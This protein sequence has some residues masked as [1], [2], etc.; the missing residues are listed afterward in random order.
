V[1]RFG[2]QEDWEKRIAQYPHVFGRH[3]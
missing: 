1:I 2:H 3:A